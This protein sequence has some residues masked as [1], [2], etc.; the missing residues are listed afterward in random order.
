MLPL[1]YPVMIVLLIPV[2]AIETIYLRRKLGVDRWLLVRRTALA[3][4]LSTLLGFPLAWLIGV[5]LEITVGGLFVALGAS[6]FP[7]IATDNLLG[8][9]AVV[10]LSAPWLSPFGGNDRWPL[11]L[12]FLVL[13]VPAFFTSFYFEWFVLRWSP[14]PVESHALRQAIWRANL[15]SY[16][17]LAV[18]GGVTLYFGLAWYLR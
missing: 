9:V 8:K 17:F 15:L 4:A 13:L 12:A 7:P 11:V 5:V 10:I 14:W 1:A 6:G 16:L 2:V 18:F 3:N